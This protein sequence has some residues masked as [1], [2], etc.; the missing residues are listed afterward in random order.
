M[1]FKELVPI[2]RSLKDPLYLQITAGLSRAIEKG[3]LPRGRKL[4]GAQKMALEL[5]V[6]KR[7]I[8]QAY[9]ELNAQD[10]ITVIPYSGTYVSDSL[11]VRQTRRL[12][13][14]TEQFPSHA[15]FPFQRL[16]FKN[17][18]SPYFTEKP[19]ADLV[20]DDGNPDI[21]QMAALAL[22]KYYRQLL[23][24]KQPNAFVTKMSPWGNK[25]LR[26]ALCDYL[27]TTRGLRAGLENILILK[28]NQMSMYLILSLLLKPGDGFAFAACNYKG[29]WDMSH[30]LG[31]KMHL[32]PSD[33]DGI[34]VEELEQ[35]CRIQAPKAVYV[36][37]HAHYPSTERLSAD[38]RVRLLELA[39][40]YHFVIIEDDYDFDYHYCQS[41]FLPLASADTGGRVIYVGGLNRCISTAVRISYVVGPADFLKELVKLK[42]TI[43]KFT[44]PILEA[45]LA[46]LIKNK[47]FIRYLRKAN[48]SYKNRRDYICKLA[49]KKLG[50][51]CQFDIP[52][53]GLAIWLRFR[54]QV[55]LEKLTAACM[56][57]GLSLPRADELYV[58]PAGAN[59]LRIGFS[60]ISNEDIFRGI[61]VMENVLKT[62]YPDA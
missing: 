31:A 35:I 7:T 10:W 54:C 57:E 45:S 9:E 38:R 53:S 11:P 42:V 6:Y 4:P 60:S 40:R 26:Y 28:G 61:C 55:D 46:L 48:K 44:D 19:C 23:E 29:I 14:Q 21:S 33:Q 8:E 25:D 24:D 59:G 2:D 58:Q 15:A 62:M 27:N 20:F 12:R 32:L 16:A 49:E 13:N 5:G 47:E 51:Y 39:E 50:S 22:Y 36:I 1:N 30:Y 37:P 3:I 41:P 52:Q 56:Q 18:I 17:E 34:I 43:D